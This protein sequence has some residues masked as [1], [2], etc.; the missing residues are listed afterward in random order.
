MTA[1]PPLREVI[2]KAGLQ[3]DKKLGQNFLLDQNITDKIVRHGNDLADQTVIEIGPGPGGLTRS[4]LQSGV[5][6]LYAI[7][8]D[9]RAIEALQPLIEYSEGRL[10]VIHADALQTDIASI[11]AGEPFHIYGNLPYNIATPLLLGWL[12]Q[13]TNNMPILSM[14]LMFQKEVADRILAVPSTKTYGRLSVMSQ[15]ICDC[16]RLFD[17]PPSVFT[18]P[19]KIESSVVHFKP[20]AHN[21]NDAAIPSFKHTEKLIKAAFAQRRKMLRSTLKSYAMH[22]DDAGIDPQARAEQLSIEN[23]IKLAELSS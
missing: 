22:F 17:L 9:P 18:P 11:T 5:K 21:G 15:W 13:I 20:K 19:P 8:Y 14:V 7:E 6:K 3:P 2:E 23:F 10:E 12:E 4:I 1:L 16:S